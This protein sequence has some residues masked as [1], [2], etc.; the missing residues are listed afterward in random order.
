MPFPRSTNIRTFGPFKIRL[1]AQKFPR[2]F[3]VLLAVV[4]VLNL[5]QASITEL[6]YDEA[7]YW[8]YAKDLAWGYFDHPP[9]VAFLIAGSR[10][11][12]Q[13]ELGVRFISVLLSVGTYI[14]L[15][16][17]VD[18]PRKKEYVP[19][20]FLLVF[21]F[22]LMNAYG[23][24]TLPDTPLLFF[25]A[26]F[27]W[28][29]KRFLAH[30]SLTASLMLGVVMA[31]LMYSKYHA[32]LVILFVLLSN[33]RLLAHKRAWLAVGVALL[34]YLPHFIWLD[35]MDWVSI[36]FHLS[37]RP[38][39][40]YSFGEFTLGYFLNLIAIIGVLFYWIYGAFFTFRAKGPFSRALVFLVYGVVLFFFVSSFNR[41]VQAQ[42]AIVITIP[43]AIIAFERLLESARIL[44]WV[45]RLG[46]VSLALLLYARAWLVDHRLFPM[47]YETHGNKAWVAALHEKAGELPVVFENSYRLAPKYEFYSGVPAMSL[48]NFMYRKNQYSIDGSEERF[49]GKK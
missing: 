34:C 20:F 32:V 29:Y 33:L 11:F 47:L 45:L 42:W 8:Y 3:I 26:L 2:L 35:Q 49:R 21:S 31:C 40:A 39:K 36:D 5:V 27:L 16:L 9:M 46:L 19:H 25:T 41:R 4:F 38:N 6:I 28:L 17:L 1:M 44:K 15:W 12:F 22:T 48:N 43:L 37:E 23:F 7:Y 10:L 14:L 18:N 13:G 24:L 30:V